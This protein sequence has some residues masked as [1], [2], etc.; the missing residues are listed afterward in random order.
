MIGIA[1]FGTPD[2]GSCAMR[3]TP[4]A[5]TACRFRKFCNPTRN[6]AI[7]RMS[8]IFSL[9]L[10]ICL[11][12]PGRESLHQ[13][14]APGDQPVTIIYCFCCLAEFPPRAPQPAAQHDDCLVTFVAV[15]HA[16]FCISLVAVLQL[17]H[18]HSSF[19]LWLIW[20]EIMQAAIR[21]T[22]ANRIINGAIVHNSTSAAPASSSISPSVFID[23]YRLPCHD[24]LPCRHRLRQNT[25]DGISPHLVIADRLF[26]V[27]E[28]PTTLFG[29]PI[30]IVPCIADQ[31]AQKAALRAF[32]VAREMLQSFFRFRVTDEGDNHFFAHFKS[33]YQLVYRF[34]NII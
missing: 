31:P 3:R 19:S 14:D 29:D 20:L 13:P 8:W 6:A 9:S 11:Y 32:S 30:A 21:P 1:A 33:R 7:S 22:A 28:R 25:A 16:Q 15:A 24:V 23:R 27:F 34:T 18:A 26:S 2:S 12:L 17:V 5:V 10:S 4:L